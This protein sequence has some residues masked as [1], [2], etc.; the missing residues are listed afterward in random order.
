MCTSHWILRRVASA[1]ADSVPRFR[2]EGL[3]KFLCSLYILCH[4]SQFTKFLAAFET[5][6]AHHCG[7]YVPQIQ[8]HSIWAAIWIHTVQYVLHAVLWAV[9]HWSVVGW[10]ANIIQ[11]SQHAP[12]SPTSI[13]FSSHSQG[14]H[15]WYR[16]ISQN[17]NFPKILNSSGMQIIWATFARSRRLHD[18]GFCK[19]LNKSSTEDISRLFCLGF[20]HCQTLFSET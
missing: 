7:F 3:Q 19:L 15:L 16:S 13:L 6:A 20:P 9:L 8:S 1:Q 12:K 4:C 2:G 14:I 18:L 17:W 10:K 11:C 5:N